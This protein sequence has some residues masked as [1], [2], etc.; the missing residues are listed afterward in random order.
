[1][2]TIGQT[3]RE[4]R[5]KQ[6]YS[7][8]QVEK[9]TKIRIELLEALEADKFDQLPPAT[10][11]Q[12]FIKSYGKF[13]KLDPEKLLAIYRREFSVKKNPPTVMDALA[14]PLRKP[15]W[16]ITPTKILSGLVIVLVL[17]F[18][19]YLWFEYRSLAGAPYLEV[20]QPIDQSSTENPMIKVSGKTENEANVEINSQEVTVDSSGSFSQEL[21][22]S[23]SATKITITA[24]SKSGKVTT[25]ERTVYLKE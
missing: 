15:G 17:A 23:D 4:E 11:V 18:F 16:M 25:V 7:L 6:F 24:T 1:M 22:L 8:D 10:F 9:V 3:L 20:S 13:L 21:K 19:G 5:E 14:N 12:G 2:R